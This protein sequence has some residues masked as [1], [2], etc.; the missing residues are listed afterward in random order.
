M[1]NTLTDLVQPAFAALDVISRELT[2]F[3]MGASRNTTADRA[4]KDT[5]VKIPVAPAANVEDI[6]PSMTLS[7]PTDQTI[8][9]TEMKITKVRRAEF[10]YSGEEQAQLRESGTIST[11]Q[12]DQIYQGM[13]SLVNEIEIDLAKEA[14]LESCRATGTA[15]TTP[16]ASNVSD[17]AKARRILDENGA[18]LTNRQ[19][20]IDTATGAAMR[21]LNQLNFVNQAGDASLL[22]QGVLG[23]IHGAMYRETGNGYNHTK[24][25]GTG[26][27]IN[28]S[29]GYPVGTTTFVV[30]GGSGT[31]VKG[32]VVTFGTDTTKYVVGTALANNTFSIN[33]PGLVKAIADNA[34]VTIGDNYS[35]NVNYASSSLVLATR[36]PFRPEG[37]DAAR[38]FVSIQDPRTGLAFDLSTYAGDHKLAYYVGIA[39]GVKGIKPEHSALLLG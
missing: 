22:R 32:D 29:G 6:S 20:G 2:G 37:G 8:P 16:F 1:P 24:G 12:A 7:E 27:V 35:A 23:D 30:D 21:S 3:T 31:I 36:L 34:T 28:K 4:S 17:S 25:T 39:W 10:G 19:M 15:G 26:K 5:A 13:R 11:L 18:P 14:A 9:V 33:A 38:D